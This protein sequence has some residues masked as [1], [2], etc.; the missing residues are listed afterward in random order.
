[1]AHLTCQGHTRAEIV[2]ILDD[3]REA[4]IEN[5][6]AL[7]GDPP[8]DLADVRPSDYAYAAELI[9]DVDRSTTSRSASPPIPRCT[10]GRPTGRPTGATWRP[11]WPA[12]TSPSPSS[13]SRPSTTCGSSTS[14]H[15]LGVDKPVLP[16]IMPV[17][18]AGQVAPDGRS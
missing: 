6:L 3:Y 13:S 18:N 16:G 11:S 10:R 8:V 5:I 4:G 12:P 9:D 14:S 15:A 17:T 2:E 1:M 7:G